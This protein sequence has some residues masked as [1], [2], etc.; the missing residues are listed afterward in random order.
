MLLSMWI[1]LAVGSL[2]LAY[3]VA[4][5][6]HYSE[7][8]RKSDE[9]VRHLRSLVIALNEDRQA[10]IAELNGRADAVGKAQA[11]M[12][13]RLASV[14]KE[15]IVVRVK[16]RINRPPIPSVEQLEAQAVRENGDTYGLG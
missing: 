5:H 9:R 11:A 1:A 4:I 6:F 3:A 12:N 7:Y 13:E 14:E 16:Q 10:E 2:A 15:Q 8:A